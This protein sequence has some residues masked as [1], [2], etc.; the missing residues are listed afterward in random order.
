MDILQKFTFYILI[1]QTV[2]FS[3]LR[4]TFTEIKGLERMSREMEHIR[5]KQ[6]TVAGQLRKA[7]MKGYPNKQKIA[8][9]KAILL[10]KEKQTIVREKM[11]LQKKLKKL[12]Q[13]VTLKN[14]NRSS[15]MSFYRYNPKIDRSSLAVDPGVQSD[16]QVIVKRGCKMMVH[17]LCEMFG[18]AHCIYFHC[19]M[20]GCAT[21]EQQ[22]LSPMHLCPV[23]LRKL[24][25]CTGI[26]TTPKVIERYFR[27]QQFTGGL[28]K[29]CFGEEVSRWFKQRA[30]TITSAA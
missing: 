17:H 13:Y 24:F 29:S 19:R 23:C 16:R 26:F 27:M 25:A 6:R 21:N 7:M 30:G 4:D 10:E 8:Q 3:L 14:Q 2:H 1:L 15:V 9:E 28:L 18:M 5:E 12:A 11:F 22:D 20:N